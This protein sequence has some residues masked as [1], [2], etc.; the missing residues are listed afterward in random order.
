MTRS[1]FTDVRSVFIAAS[2]LAQL[3]GPTVPRPP[4]PVLPPISPATALNLMKFILWSDPTLTSNDLFGAV[5]TWVK[6][7][8]LVCLVCWIAAW[9]FTGIKQGVVGRGRWFDYFGVAALVLTPL[10]VMIRVL[11]SV[12]RLPVYSIAGVPVSTLCS[13]P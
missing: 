10:S 12:K 13:S 4:A 3:V 6:A 5:L 9:L 8:S 1:T 11:E 2:A 7:M